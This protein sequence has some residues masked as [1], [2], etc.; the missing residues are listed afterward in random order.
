MSAR[1]KNCQECGASNVVGSLYCRAC[2]RELVSIP[3]SG[4]AA[5]RGPWRR[6][7]WVIGL[8]AAGGVLAAVIAY[9]AVMAGARRHQAS[10][11][12]VQEPSRG[13]LSLSNATSD[14]A[15]TRITL[16]DPETQ[17]VLQEV[18]EE[19][20]PGG[21]S[22]L[23]LDPGT[24]RVVV[25][26]AGIGQ[27]VPDWPGGSAGVGLTI[28]AGRAAIVRLQGGRASLDGLV[29]LPPELVVR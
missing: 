8:V 15:V 16:K 13:A 18:V 5:G 6:A 12:G 28:S 3:R 24:Y 29:Y 7:L 20:D 23:A 14:F 10:S 21:S 17:M 9:L 4:R 26:F 2:G 19:V 25:S 22:I 27:T 11:Y 1:R